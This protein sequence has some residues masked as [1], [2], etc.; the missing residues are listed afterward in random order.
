MGIGKTGKRDREDDLLATIGSG[1][2]ISRSGAN[3]VTLSM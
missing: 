3:I 1:N 2:D